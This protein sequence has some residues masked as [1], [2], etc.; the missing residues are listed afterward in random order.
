MCNLIAGSFL[1]QE[2]KA[3]TDTHLFCEGEKYENLP[4]GC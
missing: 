4:A 2:G 1:I 3:T